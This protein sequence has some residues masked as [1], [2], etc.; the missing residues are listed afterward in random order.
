MSREMVYFNKSGKPT[1][2]RGADINQG[3]LRGRTPLH[4][5]CASGKMT[6]LIEC[7][8]D[9]SL[10]FNLKDHCGCTPFL[11]ACEWGRTEIVKVFLDLKEVDTQATDGTGCG[12][13]CLASVKDHTSVIKLLI[14]SGR[15][16]GVPSHPIIFEGGQWTC[17]ENAKSKETRDLLTNFIETPV[18]TRL[19]LRSELDMPTASLT[20]ALVIFMCDGLLALI[21]PEHKAHN[22]S[23]F[24][25]LLARLPMELQMLVCNMTQSLNKSLISHTEREEA[26]KLMSQ[27]Y[28]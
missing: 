27:L 28:I 5:A 24:F 18:H 1:S 4:H 12:A 14:A 26:F 13:L 15:E 19:R 2:R 6:H 3:D 20:F 16:L 21:N 25:T 17:L 9:M 7:L 10:K 22:Q 8:M 11:T 23:R